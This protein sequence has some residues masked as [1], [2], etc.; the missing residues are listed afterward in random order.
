MNKLDCSVKSVES[1][2]DEFNE[3]TKP[4]LDV[5]STHTILTQ[6]LPNDKLTYETFLRVW[7]YYRAN[8]DF[9]FDKYGEFKQKYNLSPSEKEWYEKWKLE[10]VF[11]RF[12]EHDREYTLD[13]PLYMCFCLE[14]GIEY[15][16]RKCLPSDPPEFRINGVLP[17][18]LI[19]KQELR[20]LGLK[21]LPPRNRQRAAEHGYAGEL[22]Q[23]IIHVHK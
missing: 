9:S 5:Q 20:S 17:K 13:K 11:N 3:R 6:G 4:L 15:L 14:S 16:I 18:Y 8:S 21:H 2:A 7:D 23:T 19:V 12:I 10:E 1:L 22:I